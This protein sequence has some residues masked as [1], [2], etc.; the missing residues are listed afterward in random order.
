MHPIA[1][2]LFTFADATLTPHGDGN[3]ILTIFI[4][5]LNLMQLLPLTGTV[6]KSFLKPLSIHH[7]DATLTP[8]GD[9]NLFNSDNIGATRSSMQ[10]LPLTGTKPIVTGNKKA[11][12]QIHFLQSCSFN[13]KSFPPGHF[14][15]PIVESLFVIFQQYLLQINQQT[16]IQSEFPNYL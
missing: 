7:I 11:G 1:L 15:S 9:G 14:S 8:H 2:S 3:I 12:S 13:E 10:L 4:L 16:S 5:M 6:T